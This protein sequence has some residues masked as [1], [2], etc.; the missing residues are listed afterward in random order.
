MISTKINMLR[1]HLRSIGLDATETE[2]LCDEARK[3]IGEQMKSIV[4]SAVVEAENEGSAIGADE[5]LSQIRLDVDSGYIQISTD[6]GQLDF[7]LPP[8][9]MLPWMLKNAK[10]AK[11]GSRY[12]VIPVGQSTGSKPK[13]AAKDI[14]SGLGALNSSESNL[15]SMAE[16]MAQAFTGGASK[17]MADRQAPPSA[18]KPEFRIAS[19]KQDAARQWVAPAKDLDMSG[20]VMQL[21]NRMREE[22][23]RVC[24][25][26]IE[27]Y[28]RR[29]D[30]W[31]S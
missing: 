23:D 27:R 8:T 15:D 17:K 7:S 2:G 20:M 30:L 5:F 25:E 13:P 14:M 11:D 24:D 16:A 3:E 4:S 9:P 6:S 31:P 12:K 21:N 29:T 22:V 28:V 26:I 18:G 10:V 19:D 1:Q